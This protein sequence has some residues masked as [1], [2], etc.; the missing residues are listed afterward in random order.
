M[1]IKA[2]ILVIL[3]LGSAAAAQDAERPANQSLTFFNRS[4]VSS[5]DEISR[6]IGWPVPTIKKSFSEFDYDLSK[7]SF[8]AYIP[9]SYTGEKPFGLLVWVSAGG[10]RGSIPRG[11][12]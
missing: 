7:E 11:W 8:E 2:L 4:P 9:K 1:R 5:I 12:H 10:G 3:L 6:R